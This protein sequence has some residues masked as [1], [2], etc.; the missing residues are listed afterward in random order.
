MDPVFRFKQFAVRHDRAGM[1]VGTDG[2]LLGAWA[3]L[4]GRPASILDIG[5]GT[6]LIALMLAQRSDAPTID[7]VEVEAAAYEQ[8]VEN[9]EASPWNDRLFCY[10]C[11]LQEFAAEVEEPYDL[12]VSNPPFYGEVASTGNPARD[13]AR[14][15]TSLPF[16][17]LL[18]AVR[19]L[20]APGGRFCAVL[21]HREEAA[22]TALAREAGLYPGRITRVRGNPQAPLSRSLLAFTDAPT[23]LVEDA[24]TIEKVRGQ[25]TEAYQDLTRDFYLKM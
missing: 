15:R 8:C 25:Y 23:R 20:M 22:F 3:P 24:L 16:E 7:A 13:T 4:D 6:G 12:L 10:H 14:Q 2:V 17:T 19:R 5:A 9:F 18:E 11:S 1:K 21:P